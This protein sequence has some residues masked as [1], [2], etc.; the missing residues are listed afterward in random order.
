M[1][2]PERTV[3]ITILVLLAGTITATAESA[4]DVAPG[5]AIGRTWHVAPAELSGLPAEVQ[6]RTISEAA[7]K[8]EAGD[9]V[10]IHDGVYRETVTVARSGTPD[11]PIRFE[12][13]PGEHVVVTGADELRQWRKEPDAEVV[14]STPWPHR[15]IQWNKEFTHP[16]DDYHRMIGR[17]EQVLIR[18]YSLLQVLRRDK[19]SR[20]TFYVD[21][22][23]KRLYVCPRDGSDLSARNAPPVEASSRSLLWLCKGAHVRLR[24]LRF[25]YAANMAQHG[26]AKFE[27]PGG[28]V[29]DCVFEQM[30]SCGANLNAADLVVRRCTFRDNGQEG[31]R[32][33]RAHHLLLT[34]CLI[35]NNNV[36]GFD[37]GWEAGGNKLDLSR[38]AVLERS[39]FL[40]N[41]GHGVWFDIGNEQCV[42]RNCLI[43]DNED[44]GIFYEISHGLHAH[45]N[46]IVGNGFADTPGS[47]GAAAGISVSS[48]PGCLIERNL[49]FGNHEG[50]NFREA[51]RTTPRIDDA[52]KQWVWNHDETVRRNILALNR[53]AQVWGWFDIDDER[54]W[55]EAVWKPGRRESWR[56]AVQPAD[57]VGRPPDDLRLEGLKIV[58][59]GNLYHARPWQG[60]FHWGVTWKRHSK[61]ATLDDLRQE[62]TFEAGGRAADPGFAD[63]QS[64]DFRVPADSPALQMDCYPH[65]DV[66]GIRLGTLPANP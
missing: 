64:R 44:C 9:V 41:R 45:D 14:Y 23:A 56:T 22:E 2:L 12:A 38:G 46:V 62:L 21:L 15:F 57:A 16:D 17:S 6:C 58:F 42:V 43:A 31:F 49:I 24:G 27:G 19:L 11:K 5:A 51:E 32:A 20:G 53:D 33:S 40:R 47:W 48:S 52:K 39:R 26:G 59:D 63:P 10:V 65:G 1:T 36:K 30:N 55:P 54:H 18:G 4:A 66:P 50:F 3:T 8:A 13:A 29:E 35:E 7:A 60:L 28:V 34:E 25:R 37:R 61:Y